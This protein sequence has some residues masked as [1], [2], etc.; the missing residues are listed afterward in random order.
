M[1]APETKDEPKFCDKCGQKLRK[2]RVKKQTKEE[3][4]PEKKEETIVKRSEGKV[5]YFTGNYMG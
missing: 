1:N 4:K 5:V 2:T 3:P